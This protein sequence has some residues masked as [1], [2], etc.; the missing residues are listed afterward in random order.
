M[1]IIG[2]GQGGFADHLRA[3]PM[4]FK[5]ACTIVSCMH[6]RRSCACTKRN[7]RAFVP[8][9]EMHVHKC[10]TQSCVVVSVFRM[11]C[12]VT[13]R[14]ESGAVGVAAS[15]GDGAGRRNTSGSSAAHRG[16][17]RAKRD[18]ASVSRSGHGCAEVPSAGC[19]ARSSR[20]RPPR[21]SPKA[22]VAATPARAAAGA[23]RMGR[24]GWPRVN[25]KS[26]AI[27]G[28]DG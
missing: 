15:G 25:P 28:L 17:A 13:V 6:E 18:N 27:T 9:L 1:D 16:D 23:F 4:F 3:V 20:A 7:A 26:A 2:A 11:G 12:R 5:C 10:V 8:V 14:A 22:P 24:A 19:S 21:A